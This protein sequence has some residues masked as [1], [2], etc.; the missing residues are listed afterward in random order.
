[1]ARVLWLLKG[2]G[3]LLTD[4]LR[5]VMSSSSVRVELFLML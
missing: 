3:L 4:S 1:M 5:M 2:V